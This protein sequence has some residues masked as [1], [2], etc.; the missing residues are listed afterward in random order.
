[1]Q[2]MAK[3]YI[4]DVELNE[5]DRKMI[6]YNKKLQEKLKD[7]NFKEGYK[8]EKLLLDVAVELAK[9]REQRGLTQAELAKQANL[10]QQ[11]VSKLES[12]MSANVKT[13]LKVC[14]AL[15]V[16]LLLSQDDYREKDV[17]AAHI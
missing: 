5:R 1:M 2:N 15:R 9:I 6:N 12:G 7:P 13:L 8:K 16:K 14:S 4:E 3:G 11:Q 17:S 10:T